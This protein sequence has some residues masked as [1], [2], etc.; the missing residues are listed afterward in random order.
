MP[1]TFE[2][3]R[4]NVDELTLVS[5]DELR[6]SM[7]LMQR[8]CKLAVEPAGAAAMAALVGPLRKKLLGRRVGLVVCGSNIDSATYARLIQE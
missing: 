6:A 7:R 5:D 8:E 2:L 4:R 1:I 3:C